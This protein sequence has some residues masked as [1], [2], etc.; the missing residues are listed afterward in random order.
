VPQRHI[1]IAPTAQQQ[2]SAMSKKQVKTRAATPTT[3]NRSEAFNIACKMERP[4]VG[5]RTY[6]SALA[7][8]AE[9]LDDDDGVIV[10]RL[11]VSIREHAEEMDNIHE[12]FFRLNHPDRE[13]FEREGWPSD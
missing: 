11:A 10:Q 8:V 6:A 13:R 3:V 9:T 7:R 5:I 4:L 1:H 12:Y 2:E